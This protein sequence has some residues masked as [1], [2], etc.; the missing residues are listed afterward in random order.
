MLCGQCDSR[1]SRH[2]YHPDKNC[3]HFKSKEDTRKVEPDRYLV[4]KLRQPELSI[5]QSAWTLSPY[6]YVRKA[7]RNCEKFLELKL[8]ANFSMPKRAPTNL[9]MGCE[10]VLDDSELPDFD[11]TNYFQSAW[12]VALVYCNKKS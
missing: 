12:S 1:S 4:A 10:A 6:K 9:W 8:N 2:P 3:K 7:C 11:T 5:D